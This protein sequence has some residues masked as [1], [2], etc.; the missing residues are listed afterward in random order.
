[1][2]PEGMRYFRNFVFRGI[3]ITLHFAK[4]DGAPGQLAVGM[5][6]GILR[7]LPPLLE[8]PA[9]SMASVFNKAVMI[10]IAGAIDPVQGSFDIRPNTAQE[11][12]IVGSL[13]IL[14]R[15]EHKQRG[16]IDTSV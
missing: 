3:D 6:Y 1:M 7:V 10:G 16:R 4:S 5:K 2:E 8:Q 12:Q 15:E 13:V 9:F 14:S 11:V